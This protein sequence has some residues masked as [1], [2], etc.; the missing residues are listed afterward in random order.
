MNFYIFSSIALIA[1]FGSCSR[2]PDMGYGSQY[3]LPQAEKA[4]L[5]ISRSRLETL[6]PET[7]QD[8]DGL[9]EHVDSSKTNLYL[10][11]IRPEKAERGQVSGYVYGVVME[12]SFPSED[13]TSY[14]SRVGEIV[15]RWTRLAGQPSVKMVLDSSYGAPPIKKRVIVWRVE[16][17]L[18]RLT[19]DVELG[20]SYAQTRHLTAAVLDKSVLFEM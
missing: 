3:M 17:V 8:S 13:T 18:L 16:E 15:T 2:I 10:M 19:H 12:H 9:V 5:G 6:R 11:G 1:L 20:V 7:Y 4:A 14:N